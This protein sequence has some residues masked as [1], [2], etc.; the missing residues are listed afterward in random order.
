MRNN[1]QKYKKLY[2]NIRT[3]CEYTKLDKGTISGLD[4]IS[5]HISIEEEYVEKIQ[6]YLERHNGNIGAAI[7]EIIDQVEKYSPYNTLAIDIS[8]LNWMLEETED[9][10][11]S[12]VVLDELI[13]PKLISSIEKLGKY[14]NSRFNNLG[15]D[16]N[17]LLTTD[18]DSLPSNVLIEIRGTPKKI[19]F[20][21]RMISQYLTKNLLEIS[22][23][24]I[25]RVVNN[26]EYIKI[27]MSKSSKKESEESLSKFF[28]EMDDTLK[29]IKTRPPFWK[30]L[31]KEHHLTNYN[32][33]T[34]HKNYFE[35]LLANNVP[36][37]EIMIEILA[38]RPVQDI[39]LEE[40]LLM[41][42]HVYETARVVD[43][44][45]I[46]NDKI[47]LHHNYRTKEAVD[48]LKR[49]LIMLLD[50]N[51]HL[52]DA[53]LS[54]N[55]IILKHRPDVGTKI[56]EI[57]NNLKTSN[58]RIDQELTMFA[59]FLSGLSDIPDMPLSFAIL[60]RRIGKTLMQEYKDENSIK[61]WSLEDFKKAIETID[62]RLNRKSELKLE[63]GIL[64]YVIAKCNIA[65]EK[66][67]FNPYLCHTMRETFKG[68]LNYVFGDKVELEFNK[69]LS[70]GD[71]LCEVI[72]RTRQ[73]G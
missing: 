8:L 42:K 67:K 62:S 60:G 3:I 20:V 6:P 13:D 50:A 15:W 10:L 16:I 56:N 38:K 21:A 71:N 68:A 51:G 53:T 34:V 17:I 2:A 48:K 36:L 4:M 47:M 28:G 55:M 54:T 24:A 64:K 27:E 69:S 70:R 18:E 32:M 19:K 22:P 57:V 44:V 29:I 12:D 14:V 33:V 73:Q 40:M 11:I 49:I 65:T 30:D 9:M 25:R 59:T 39:P 61:T 35:D 66:D 46:D 7:K 52:Y 72:I 31:I 5:R 26:D 37:G 63:K 23:V 58:N 1:R 41:I 45:E 43:K